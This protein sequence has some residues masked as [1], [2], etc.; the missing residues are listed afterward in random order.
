MLEYISWVKQYLRLTRLDSFSGPLTFS[1]IMARRSLMQLL[2]VSLCISFCFIYTLR[3]FYSTKTRL[4]TS[5]N[6]YKRLSSDLNGNYYY[7][8][9]IK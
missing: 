4:N 9:K 1:P 6:K 3:L 8:Y 2:D 7:Y 5:T